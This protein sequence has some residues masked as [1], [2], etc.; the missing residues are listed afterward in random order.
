MRYSKSGIKTAEL[1][2]IKTA[3]LFGND[4]D[5]SR[6]Y[7]RFVSCLLLT[8]SNREH[9]ISSLPRATKYPKSFIQPHDMQIGLQNALERARPGQSSQACNASTGSNCQD[10][11]TVGI[12]SFLANI[13]G[14]KET[15]QTFEH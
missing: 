1:F 7:E 4:N 5:S 10:E 14:R 3:E 9:L 2:G 12:T 13:K 15:N 11:A 6:Q 8:A